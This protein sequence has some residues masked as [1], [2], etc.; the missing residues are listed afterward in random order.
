MIDLTQ[1]TQEQSWGLEFVVQQ[2]NEGKPEGEQ[3]TTVQEYADSVF[4]SA[5]D[6]YYSQ[7]LKHKKDMALAMFDAL[8]PEEQ[9]A[10]VAQL[11]VPDVVK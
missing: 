3:P 10:L 2:L 7:L 11:G 6:S 9:A 4:K 1:L 8:S 5:C